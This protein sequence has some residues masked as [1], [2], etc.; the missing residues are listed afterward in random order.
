MKSL[1]ILLL[2]E[3]PQKIKRL[4]KGA[5]RPLLKI[6]KSIFWCV[7]FI[8]IWSKTVSP[9]TLPFHH[10]PSMLCPW[11]WLQNLVVHK[12]IRLQFLCPLNCLTLTFTYPHKFQLSLYCIIFIVKY[13]MDV[14][15]YEY[16]HWLSD[17]DNGGRKELNPFS[18]KRFVSD[19]L[20]SRNKRV[21]QVFHHM[22]F[23]KLIINLHY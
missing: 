1:A 8:K 16:L 6:P 12:A 3:F 15:H 9:P 10:S 22:V 2:Y 5:K 17:E 19:D 11:A 18:F 14:F 13:R 23:I 20:A 4:T 7:N 21:L